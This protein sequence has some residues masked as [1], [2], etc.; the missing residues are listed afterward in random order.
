MD[1]GQIGLSRGVRGI[2]LSSQASTAKVR[3]ME[4]D[5]DARSNM[6]VGQAYIVV[7]SGSKIHFQISALLEGFHP[8]TAQPYGADAQLSP[9]LVPKESRFRLKKPRFGGQSH[10]LSNPRTT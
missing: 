8:S 6:S 3:V 5:E 1:E 4:T 7:V 10:R 9:K 2:I